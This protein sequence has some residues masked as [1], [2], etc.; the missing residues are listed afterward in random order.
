MSATWTLATT[1]S[2]A[3]ERSGFGSTSQISNADI[4]LIIN[5]IYR[6]FLPSDIQNSTLEGFHS[7]TTSSGVGVYDIDEEVLELRKPATLDDGDGDQVADLNFYLDPVPFFQVYPEDSSRDD[8]IPE[9]LLLYGNENSTGVLKDKQLY[10]RPI[11][12]GTYTIKLAAVTRP[13][14]LSSDSD[15]FVDDDMGYLVGVKAAIEI[16]D[17]K[18]GGTSPRKLDLQNDQRFY[19]SRIDNK[20]IKQMS[21]MRSTPRF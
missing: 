6:S 13:Q 10:V 15:P 1:R 16:I 17:T 11:P 12:D 18:A 8:G 7:L 9:S 4:D 3:R 20:Q 14:I 19:E 21:A 2:Y 5:R